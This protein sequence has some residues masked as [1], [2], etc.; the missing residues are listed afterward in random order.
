MTEKTPNPNP[1]RGWDR[2]STSATL[3]AMSR[4]LATLVLLILCGAGGALL[5]RWLETGYWTLVGF[6]VGILFT[7]V[8]MLYVV[9]ISEYERKHGVGPYRSPSNGSDEAKV[10]ELGPRSSE[11]FPLD[12]TN[13]AGGASRMSGPLSGTSAGSSSDPPTP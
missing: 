7:M 6:V 8:G 9:K 4:I 5:D 11:G 1:K 10:A 13:A 12:A 2:D 3:S